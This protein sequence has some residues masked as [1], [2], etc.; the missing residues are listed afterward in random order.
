MIIIEMSR[1]NNYISIFDLYNKIKSS[2]I[3]KK[4]DFF[5]NKNFERTIKLVQTA[6]RR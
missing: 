3:C 5:K 2:H 4:L 1:E 6:C